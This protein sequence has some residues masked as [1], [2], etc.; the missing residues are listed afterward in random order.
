MSLIL[1]KSIL[2]FCVGIYI[3]AKVKNR[4]V[5]IKKY[6]FIGLILTGSNLFLL[7]VGY[8]LVGMT[9][10]TEVGLLIFNIIISVLLIV[11]SFKEMK[12]PVKKKEN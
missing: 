6:A 5:F 7:A 1:P 12:K 4:D 9:P 11:I 10:D 2:L 8:M 3:W